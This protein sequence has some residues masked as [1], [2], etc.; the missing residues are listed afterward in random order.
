MLWTRPR[1][2]GKVAVDDFRSR[3][4]PLE[5]WFLK[6]VSGEL[7]FLVDWILRR[8]SGIAEVRI[9]LWVRGEGR[10]V[11][12]T[13]DQWRVVG[14]VVDIAGCTF[15]PSLLTG[16]VDDITWSLV[17]SP[18]ESRI[19]PVPGPARV[20]HPFD[21]ELVVRPRACISGQIEV[22]GETFELTDAPATLTHYWGRRLPDAWT[23]VSADGLGDGDVAVEAAV[24]R[25]RLWGRP[26]ASITGGYVVVDDG[27]STSRVI[28]PVYGLVSGWGDAQRFGIRARAWGRGITISGGASASAYNDLGEGIAQTLLGD[29]SV[30]GWGECT[31]RAGLEFRGRVLTPRR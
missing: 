7:A 27:G 30:T 16:S 14:D 25:T 31:G 8:D 29:L 18:G 23:W 26:R 9:S 24:L 20:L 19:D 22:A 12:T 6:V 15:T 21:L 10:V 28:A 1:A 11:R 4:A 3:D 5:Y 13:S 2:H 17:S